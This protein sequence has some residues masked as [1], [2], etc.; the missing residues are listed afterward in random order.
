MLDAQLSSIEAQGDAT[1]SVSELAKL[2]EQARQAG[3]DFLSNVSASDVEQPFNLT[4]MLENP[5]FKTD[6][7]SGW[8]TD[9][10]P[11]YGG[12]AAEFY[13]TTFDFYQTL[14]GMPSGIYQ[15]RANTF[16][17][18]GE[19][20]A[21]FAQYSNGSRNISTRL[22]S[23]NTSEPVKHIC[24]DRQDKAL[25]TGDGADKQLSDG[26]YVPITM[27]GASRYFAKNLYESSVTAEQKTPNAT[28]RMGIRC[29]KSEGYYWSI[30]DNFRLLF[31]GQNS[32]ILG[33]SET[34]NKQL[35]TNSRIYDLQGRRVVDS[36]LKKGLYIV[37]GKKVAITRP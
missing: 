34:E 27:N 31:Y 5:D 19:T 9:K 16:Q 26:T 13:E 32:A 28:L 14:T 15:L 37:S 20:S 36:Q 11:G 25:Y 18:P 7:V 23:G 10:T 29:N 6:A 17:R 2:T 33:I 12:G 3:M 35:G 4:F 30:F 21:V 24:D 1:T 22:Y 8:T